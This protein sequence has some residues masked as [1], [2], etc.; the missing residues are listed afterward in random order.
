LSEQ[1]CRTL[2]TAGK[3]P[4]QDLRAV[5]R[6]EKWRQI[7]FEYSKRMFSWTSRGMAWDRA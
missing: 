3:D 1:A 4:R 7:W 5:A 2:F 6:R